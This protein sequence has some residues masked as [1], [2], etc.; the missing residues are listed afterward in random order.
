MNNGSKKTSR[1]MLSL[2]AFD[3]NRSIRITIRFFRGCYKKS[4][5]YNKVILMP[6][7]CYY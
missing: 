7:Y 5:H 4:I 1:H 3:L 6:L 2:M